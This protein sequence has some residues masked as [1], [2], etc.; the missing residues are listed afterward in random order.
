MYRND[1]C[2]RRGP[3]IG[4]KYDERMTTTS[5]TAPGWSAAAQKVV[6]LEKDYLLQTYSRYPVVMHRGKGCYLYDV[7]GKRY[8]D[9][10]AGIGVNALGH[11]HPRIVRVI[12][13]QTNLLLHCSNL[14]YHEYQGPLAKKLAEISGLPRTFFCNSGT[15]AMEG[16]LKMVRS[17]GGRISP[18]KLEIIALDNSFHGRTCGALSVT[19]QEKY[20]KDFEP[21]LAGVKFVPPNDEAAL[22]QAVGDRTA[23]IVIEWVQGEG[24]IYPLEVPY[25]RKAKELAERHNA[26]LVCDEIQC[27][28]G[29]PGTYFA[30]QLADPVILPDVMVAAKP[31]ACGLPLG[32]IVANE[33]AAA[34]IGPGMHGSTFGG[35]PLACRVALEFLDILESLLPHIHQVGG[36]FRMELAALAKHHSFIKEVRGYGL[37]IGVELDIPG[38]EIV[39]DA[40]AEGMLINC[41]HDTVLRFLPPYIIQDAEIDHAVKTLAKIFKKAKAGEGS[42]GV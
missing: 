23:G 16:A 40:L 13:E 7:D 42:P 6:D 17:H 3:E 10:M 20:R 25:V 34:A 32:V 35:G 5:E 21:L 38:K 18:E 27:G 11:A 28:V 14:Y 41:T 36:Y 31:L 9:L 1:S 22:E 26:L 4:L 37:M 33:K 8:L 39:L 19:G 30:Y 2:R 24:G 12:R 15:E 29:R